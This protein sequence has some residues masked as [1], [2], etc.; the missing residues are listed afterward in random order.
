MPT[1]QS[2]SRDETGSG[3]AINAAIQRLQHLGI[4]LLA[5]DFDQTLIDIHTHGC[6]RD[7]VE[8]LAAHVRP[9]FQDLV[10]AAMA[11]S[12][13]TT[14]I[15]VAIVTLSCQSDL[16]Q[17]VLESFVGA[18]RAARIPIRG[19]DEGRWP[20]KGTGSSSPRDGKQAH[21]ASAVE[22]LQNLCRDDDVVINK[23]TTLLIDDD[24]RNV[25]IALKDEVRAV[26]F[27]PSK[28]ENLL[29]D[30]ANMV[31]YLLYILG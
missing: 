12:T 10:R 13:T 26:W 7:G 20:Y 8:E 25:R 28:P 30:I 18:E 6:W 11:S 5:L 22:E 14:T 1:T 4:N 27:D 2:N 3:D 24:H 29:P 21:I 16:I 15:H 31:R 23:N 19:G 17:S 9:V